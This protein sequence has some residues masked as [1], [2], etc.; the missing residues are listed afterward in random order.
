MQIFLPPQKGLGRIDTIVGEL[1]PLTSRIDQEKCAKIASILGEGR[2]LEICDRSEF[3]EVICVTIGDG[4]AL[5][6]GITYSAARSAG[7]NFSRYHHQ[8][9][10]GTVARFR[11]SSRFATWI[12]LS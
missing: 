11:I 12:T 6:S 4:H 9:E 3:I 5:L 8:C 1:D 7:R 10:G 2:D